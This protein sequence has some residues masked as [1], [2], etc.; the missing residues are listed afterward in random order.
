M[1]PMNEPAIAATWLMPIA[2]PRCS[3]GNASAMI[4]LAFAKSIAPPTP[5]TSRHSTSHNAPP[6][7]RIGSSAKIID[8][9]EK[10]AKP[11]L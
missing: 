1:S 6:P 4:A 11:A 5:C 10:T 8:A 3:T 9:I 7:P 2:R